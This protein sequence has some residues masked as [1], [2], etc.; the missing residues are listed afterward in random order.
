[1]LIGM[2][3]LAFLCLAAVAMPACL[4]FFDDHG[5]SCDVVPLEGAP[6]DPAP[7][8]NPH[9][10]TCE[11]FGPTC[12]PDCGPCPE[13]TARVRPTPPIPS[14]GQ[15]GSTCDALSEGQCMVNPSCR[16][17]NDAACAVSE[18]CP[19]DFLGCFPTDSFIDKTVVCEQARD[20]ETCSRNPECVAFHR[21]NVCVTGPCERPFAFCMTR[22][23]SPGQCNLPVACDA[24]PPS[25]PTG[26]TPGVVDACWSGVCIPDDLCGPMPFD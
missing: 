25:C 14:W 24:R 13:A 12:N 11:S 5:K 19:T 22:G 8:R 6:L 18:L 7:L 10:L 20:G 21:N 9:T 26:T 15:C 23:R 17:V 16:V 1:M 2:V 3:R 4:L